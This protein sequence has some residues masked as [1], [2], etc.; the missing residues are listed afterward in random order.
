MHH[1]HFPRV[2]SCNIS[3]LVKPENGNES[4]GQKSLW[5]VSKGAPAIERWCLQLSAEGL[6]F[7]TY[8][9]LT[10]IQWNI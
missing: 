10:Y 4:L 8:N 2:S 7:L 3:E 9:L 1:S 5:Y 6:H